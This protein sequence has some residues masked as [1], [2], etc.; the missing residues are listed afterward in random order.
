MKHHTFIVGTS[1]SKHKDAYYIASFYR[2][3]FWGLLKEAG[4]TDTQIHP[5]DYRQLGKQYGIYLSEIVDPD[6][7]IING[8]SNIE[9]YQIE[10]GMKTLI[11]RIE[12][13]NPN[14]IGLKNKNAATWFHQYCEGKEVTTTDNPKHQREKNRWEDYGFL[15]E[16]DYFGVDYYLLPTMAYDQHYRKEEYVRFWEECREDVETFRDLSD[17]TENITENA[18]T[19]RQQETNRSDPE[20]DSEKRSEWT[21]KEGKNAIAETISRNQNSGSD[22]KV[23]NEYGRDW[24]MDQTTPELANVLQSLISEISKLEPLSGPH[25]NQ[26]YITFKKKGGRKR[27]ITITANKSNIKLDFQWCDDYRVTFAQMSDSVGVPVERIDTHTRSGGGPR[28]TIQPAD[29]IDIEGLVD[30]SQTLIPLDH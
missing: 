7:H 8:D 16:W 9:P 4:I 24:H 22:N 5:E 25:R 28:I 10:S 6:E 20:N 27:H 21:P 29:N 11:N 15:R 18:Q 2:D 13:D 17:E 19:T 14:R 12:S 26:N 23:T 30:L 1:K 3:R